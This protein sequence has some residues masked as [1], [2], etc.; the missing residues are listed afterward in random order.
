MPSL[1]KDVHIL[2]PGHYECI[3]IYGVKN[4]GDVIKDFELGDHPQLWG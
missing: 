2:I 3:N 4:F 1:S